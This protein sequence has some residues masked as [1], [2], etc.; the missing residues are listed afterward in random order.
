MGIVFDQSLN[1]SDSARFLNLTVDGNI[2]PGSNNA[3]NSGESSFRWMGVYAQDYNAGVNGNYGWDNDSNTYISNSGDNI[4]FHV[5][6]VLFAEFEEASRDKIKFNGDENKDIDFI[7]GYNGGKA[8]DVDGAT[9]NIAMNQSLFINN[10][11]SG[12]NNYE[13]LEVKWDSNVATINTAASG[14]GAQR[15]LRLGDKTNTAKT[16]IDVTTNETGI[17]FYDNDT[18]IVDITD[19]QVRSYRKII[20][21]I[22]G[23]YDLGSSSARWATTCTKGFMT[24]VET[25]TAVSD[26]LDVKN[27]VALCDCTSNAITINLPAAS[28]ASG[29]QYHIKK[30]DSSTNAVTID[31]DG[32]ETIDGAATQVINAQYQTL[33]IV[34]DG[35]NW[36]II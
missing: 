31:A 21:G 29:L 13:R 4:V 15:T 3:H 32:S 25:F 2:K 26:T 35:S 34:S 36:H 14:T 6:G 30:T 1:S 22:D 23:V 7:V 19:S 8:I 5:G 9:G 33:T 18:W 12:T 11:Y 10:F 20:P 27:N 17:K 28:T 24:D 16:Y